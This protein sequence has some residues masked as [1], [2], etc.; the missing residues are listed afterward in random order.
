[1]EKITIKTI[2]KVE[3]S[4][5]NAYQITFTIGKFPNRQAAGVFAAHILMAKD[6]LLE[7]TEHIDFTNDIPLPKRTLH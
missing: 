2:M 5:D 7:E 4:A 1:M 3:K 6:E